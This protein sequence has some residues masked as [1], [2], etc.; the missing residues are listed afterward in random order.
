M[1]SGEVEGGAAA[2]L[3]VLAAAANALARLV[4]VAPDALA[5]PVRAARSGKHGHRQ[6]Q[7]PDTPCTN[8]HNTV[9][10]VP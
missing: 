9:E 3:A 5:R 10:K 6:D 2:A 7:R 1:E 8:K 4:V